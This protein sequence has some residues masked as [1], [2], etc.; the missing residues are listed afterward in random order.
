M[1]FTAWFCFQSVINLIETLFFFPSLFQWYF[2][3]NPIFSYVLEE[4]TKGVCAS[5]PCRHLG[6]KW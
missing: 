5:E 1:A 6:I 4:N 3:N 2:L